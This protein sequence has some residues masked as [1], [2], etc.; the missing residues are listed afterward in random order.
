MPQGR[1]IPG[2]STVYVSF[3]FFNVYSLSLE[4]ERERKGERE[5]LICCSTYLCI[6]R[7]ILLCALTGD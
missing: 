7:L 4:R 5:T 2:S 3:R 6:H 1:D